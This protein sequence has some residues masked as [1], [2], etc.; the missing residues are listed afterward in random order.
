V[1]PKKPILEP[2]CRNCSATYLHIYFFAPALLLE[3]ELA[4]LLELEDDPL[5]ELLIEAAAGMAA[6]TAG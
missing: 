4:L 2:F 6:G 1:L 5:D 3:L